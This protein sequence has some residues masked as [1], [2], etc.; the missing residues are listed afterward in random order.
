MPLAFIV[1][2]CVC[3]VCVCV[4]CV[5]GGGRIGEESNVIRADLDKG[6]REKI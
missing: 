2:V 3:D 6:W 4:K 1:F 5:G